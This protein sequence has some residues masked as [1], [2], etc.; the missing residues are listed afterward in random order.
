MAS[1][2]TRRFLFDPGNN[3]LLNIESVNILD[4]TP[5]GSI[6]GIGTGTVL[7]V[8]EFE[9]GAFLA[10][11]Q[12][13]GASD[14]QQNWGLLGY[15]YG[16]V[17]G[18]NPCAASRYADQTL[19]AENWNGNAF[20]QLNGKQFASLIVCRVNTSV[21]SITLTSRAFI[22]G[23]SS[24][25]Y[26]MAP[27]DVLGLDVGA[28]AQTAT[29]TAT[30]ATVT[31][32]AGTYSSV[33]AGMTVLLGYDG[34]PNF[35][36]TF[37]AGDT[38]QANVLARINQYAG[39]TIAATV[40]GTTFS[41]TGIQQGNQAQIRV[42]SGS[43]GALT[44]LGLSA[45]TTFGTGNVANIQAVSEAEIQTVVQGA[46]SN[47]AVEIDPNGNI[48]ISKTTGLEQ[49][50]VY[51]TSATTTNIQ[52]SLGF[53]PG[54]QGSNLGVG[55]V[56]ATGGTFPLANTGTISLAIDDNFGAQG[57]N[58][59]VPF[60]VT[61]TASMALSAF[62]S[63]VNTAAGATVCYADSTTGFTL[64]GKV[65]GGRVNVVGASAANVLSQ[66][67]LAVGIYNGT[68]LPTSLIQAGTIVQDS[69]AAHVFVTMQDVV[70]AATGVTIGG[71]L[72][73]LQ[74]PWTVP[75][76]H[77][78]DNTLG[79]GATAGTI[80]TIPNPVQSFSLS[81]INNQVITAALTDAQIDAAYIN[82]LNAT[83]DVNSVS[84]TA[85]IIYSARQS[86]TVR[87]GLK[88]NALNASANGCYGRMAVVR[89]PLGTTKQVAMSSGAEP[90]VGA[91][92]DQRVIFTWPQANTFV[93]IIGQRGT[94]G[95]LGYT[96]SGN[97]DVGADGFMASILSQ[98][99]PEENPG[100][101]TPF[102]TA[103]NSPESSPN[104]AGLQITDYINL[105]AAG[106]CALRM[107]QGTA[108]FQSGCTSVDPNVYPQFVRISRRRMAD[109]IQDSLALLA[110]GF[111]K[112]LSTAAR[113]AGLTSEI[114]AFMEQL[115]NKGNPNGQRIAGYT[116]DAVTGNTPDTL[117][118]GIFRIIINVQT[119]PSLDSIVLQTTIGE[120]VQVQEVFPQ[121][122]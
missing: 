33:T 3:V 40:S 61:I 94:A 45:A 49:D 86:N 85:N 39:F 101:D 88:A 114:R 116:V 119:L 70:F 22:T 1:V 118:L 34:A 73:P 42:V 74:G 44:A 13:N 6:A 96:Y 109:F 111:G 98:L 78:L 17:Q 92:R 77:A 37:L 83:L 18:Y 11:T 75:I 54:M 80:T 122:A 106:V 51:V 72:A 53:V 81:A 90:G 82:A 30:A 103:I 29:F 69:T 10:P 97:V 2:F 58:G 104:A 102:T 67:N 79:L 76:R 117:A 93:P 84:K 43:A 100:Q 87:K 41:L 21:G 23:N 121:A 107:D 7:I 25:R 110:S 15:T 71:V 26:F 108:I 65:P 38:T 8:G 63:A 48:R 27:N 105:K 35:T 20:V 31:S 50:Y 56:L 89:T 66:M 47:T 4:L 12:V 113:R 5:P 62:V 19:A 95:G 14:L 52:N 99:P 32:A 57:V 64:V 60:T 28:G 59:G 112:K 16:G 9:N 91:Y 55:L 24:F 46:I 36:V 115:L 68:G 120:Q